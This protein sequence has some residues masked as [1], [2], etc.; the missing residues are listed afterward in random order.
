MRLEIRSPRGKEERIGFLA[1]KRTSPVLTPVI[2]EA[3][4]I[5]GGDPRDV[6]IIRFKVGHSKRCD[7]KSGD[8]GLV[9]AV[10]RPAQ[11]IECNTRG[12]DSPLRPFIGTR[13]TGHRAAA[14]RIAHPIIQFARTPFMTSTLLAVIPANLIFKGNVGGRSEWTVPGPQVICQV[15]VAGEPIGSNC[16]SRGVLVREEARKLL[17]VTYVATGT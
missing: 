11:Q 12:I 1:A 8:I 7:Q 14:K 4:R 5:N 17:F 9:C 2:R 10:I 16:R 15:A 6:S 13:P 3:D